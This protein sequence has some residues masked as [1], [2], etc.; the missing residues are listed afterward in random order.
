MGKTSRRWPFVVGLIALLFLATA[1]FQQVGD[2]EQGQAV[3]IR[4]T[5]TLTPMPSD[6]PIPPTET[7]TEVQ[8]QDLPIVDNPTETEI[9]V[10]L[11]SNTPM[12]VA[13]N[14]NMTLIPTQDPFEITATALVEQ[15]TLRF[16]LPTTQT[17]AALG[18][19]LFTATPTATETSP[20][21]I[22]QPGIIPG[23]D[24]VYEV[25]A[26]DTLWNISRR[27]D[28]TVMEIVSANGISNYN[29]IVIGERL[30]IPH[31]GNSGYIP[32]ATSTPIPSSTPYGFG[33]NADVSAAGVV[34]TPV[35]CQ[36][37]YTV[38]EK[39]TLFNIAIRYGVTVQALLNA[40]ST[41]I[42]DP[43]RIN[44]G[45]VICIPSA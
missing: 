24:C 38:Q 40:N 41:I 8:A 37:Q 30:T 6:T 39:D 4:S 28:N 7:A 15:A 36:T 35:V 29:L 17:A 33:V 1:C 10:F 13:Q 26:G 32:P 11:P 43:N 5:D 25:R 23:A 9:S 12:A 34:A 21:G 42:F 18:I 44:M 45:D 27:F 2:E 22:Q 3:S 31:C 19:G 16:V 14:D 20:F